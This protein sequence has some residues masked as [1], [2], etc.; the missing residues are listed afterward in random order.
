[1]C[2]NIQQEYQNSSQVPDMSSGS[3]LFVHR[4][5]SMLK[6]SRSTLHELP[7]WVDTRCTRLVWA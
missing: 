7:S 1:M 6:H 2:G 5:V 3:V 4:D